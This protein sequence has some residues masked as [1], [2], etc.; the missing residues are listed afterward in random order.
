LRYNYNM[1]KEKFQIK[2]LT[3]LF[4]L[5]PIL[6]ASTWE[7]ELIDVRAM[8]MGNCETAFP[9]NL[10]SLFF[11]PALPSFKENEKCAG[12]NF[13]L[14]E[15]RKKYIKNKRTL[16][17]YSFL[18]KIKK[19]TIFGGH[20]TPFI[21]FEN[22][23]TNNNI[24]FSS[25]ILV[26][27]YSIGIGLKLNNKISS[28]VSFD[29]LKGRYLIEFKETNLFRNIKKGEKSIGNITFGIF[30]KLKECISFGASFKKDFD[31]KIYGTDET[32]Q[33]DI[34]SYSVNYTESILKFPFVIRSGLFFK[35]SN[36]LIFLFDLKFSNW[37]KV[38]G[39]HIYDR[40][41]K[42]DTLFFTDFKFRNT[43]S[44]K[45]GFEYKFRDKFYIRAGSGYEEGMVKSQNPNDETIQEF[46]EV[47][48]S[49]GSG[50]RLRNFDINWGIMYKTGIKKEYKTD[51]IVTGFSLEIFF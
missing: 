50:I 32:Y 40:F 34:D 5:C 49:V 43:F 16:F 7:N 37:S 23:I 29:F 44:I 31:L 22:N 3:L 33:Y 28:G 15:Q 35:K 10:F 1:S 30:A 41:T 39:F 45:G 18:I 13:I 2:I 24:S 21:G 36:N 20:F 46:S 38:K 17:V 48:M 26:E 8:G 19:F 4:I 25:E 6:K 14:K 12:I 27:S 9:L 11:N 47:L 51:I 42:K